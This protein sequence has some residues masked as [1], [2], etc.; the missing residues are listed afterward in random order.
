MFY[1]PHQMIGKPKSQTPSVRRRRVGGE[2]KNGSIV[3]IV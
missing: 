1:K 2:I 3:E